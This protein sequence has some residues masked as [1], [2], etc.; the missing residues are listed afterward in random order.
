MNN[1]TP[2]YQGLNYIYNKEKNWCI[3]EM[4]LKSA[5]NPVLLQNALDCVMG[6]SDYF[7]L[8]Y[9]NHLYDAEL[10]FEKIQKT[11]SSWNGNNVQEAQKKKDLFFVAYQHKTVYLGWNHFLTDGRG[12]RQFLMQIIAAYCNLMYGTAFSL[13]PLKLNTEVPIECI[14]KR[15]RRK[16][17]GQSACISE[18]T[19]PLCVHR[20]RISRDDVIQMAQKNDVKPFS[21]ILAVVLNVLHELNP[22]EYINY[23]YP[24]DAR[25]ATNQPNALY[26][27]A[28]VMSGSIIWESDK[29]VFCNVLNQQIESKLTFQEIMEAYKSEMFAL[30]RLYS[31]NASP[32]LKI[33]A[34]EMA[35]EKD[36]TD[37]FFSYIGNALEPQ[38]ADMAE[39]ISDC[40]YGDIDADKKY[41]ILIESFSFG[42]SFNLTVA[43][44][45]GSPLFEKTIVAQFR[46]AGIH[47]EI[48]N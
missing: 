22:I 36:C 11:V 43:E 4:T 12:A 21:Y 37:V 5:I 1:L 24:V 14:S 25:A 13:T 31:M 23:I 10:S 42:K 29:T 15:T 40:W 2:L 9:A 8:H 38:Y 34:F 39:Y 32:D 35:Q 3:I 44:R 30:I 16:Q 19:N 46:A 26:N 20:V 33:R 48:A 18:Y 7:N 6:Q 27:A 28:C 45:T 17:T 41:G 47:A